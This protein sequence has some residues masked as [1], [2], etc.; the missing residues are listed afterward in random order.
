MVECKFFAKARKTLGVSVQSVH[1][2]DIKEQPEV[3]HSADAS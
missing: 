2:F 3:L 1:K